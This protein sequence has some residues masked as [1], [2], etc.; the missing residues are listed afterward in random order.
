MRRA[1][2]TL[3]PLPLSVCRVG[4]SG[5]PRTPGPRP[6][7]HF[8]AVVSLD[9][10]ARTLRAQKPRRG[11][12]EAH[13]EPDAP[14]PQSPER[15]EELGGGAAG[16]AQ[17]NPRSRETLAPGTR[18][19]GD[20]CCPA[21]GPA[22][23]RRG[24]GILALSPGAQLNPRPPPAAVPSSSPRDSWAHPAGSRAEA[25]PDSC[26][27]LHP[28]SSPCLAW[29][30]SRSPTYSLRLFG[31]RGGGCPCSLLPGSL[32]ANPSGARPPAPASRGS[33]AGL[34][35]PQGVP[36]RRAASP[37]SARSWEPGMAFP[38]SRCSDSR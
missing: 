37:R 16:A 38:G 36:Y 6:P 19:E 9:F 10:A 30:N 35:H 25:A 26:G 4:R 27:H 23:T 7:F 18:L 15:I 33:P 28:E 17:R 3:W 14:C 31:A 20:P 24:A 22:V 1:L 8:S 12:L 5:R 29:P 34:R 13:A 21:A 32:P 2:A 11:E